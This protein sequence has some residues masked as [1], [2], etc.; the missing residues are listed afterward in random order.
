MIRLLCVFSV[1]GSFCTHHFRCESS[2]QLCRMVLQAQ[3][4]EDV[5][6][7]LHSEWRKFT[8]LGRCCGG[9]R[10]GVGGVG[11]YGTRQVTAMVPI[12]SLISGGPCLHS[13]MKGG[14]ARIKIEIPASRAAKS[15]FGGCACAGFRVSSEGRFHLGAS[16]RHGS[17]GAR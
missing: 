13:E 12:T 11:R 14:G 1:D 15:W 7:S 4:Q 3:C 17:H 5:E 16:M 10:P 2:A 8:R 6:A 9:C